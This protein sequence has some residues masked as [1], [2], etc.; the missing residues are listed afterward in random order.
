MGNN[1]LSIRFCIGCLKHGSWV[2]N[3]CRNNFIKQIPHCFVCGKIA[4]SYST[5]EKCL[6]LSNGIHSLFVCFQYNKTTRKYLK[7][8]KFKSS[9]A[10]LEEILEIIKREITEYV[11][12]SGISYVDTILVPVPLH[13]KRLRERGFNQSEILA[14]KLSALLNI[15]VGNGILE[16]VINTKPQTKVTHETR[17]RNVNNAFSFIAE[18]EIMSC[19]KHIILIDDVTTT[20]STLKECAKVIK[21]A[22]PEITLY[23]LVLFKPKPKFS[24]NILVPEG[25]R[26]KI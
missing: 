14:R 24:V 18:R 17:Q 5:H 3:Q 6:R 1:F 13:R 19:I 2:C 20:G 8:I 16:K 11:R 26:D 10:L 15:K 23:G 4:K 7:Y 21:A 22:Y 12:I 9:Y 25:D